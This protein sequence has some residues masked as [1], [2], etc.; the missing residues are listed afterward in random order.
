MSPPLLPPPDSD[1]SVPTV[2]TLPPP[3]KLKRKYDEVVAAAFDKLFTTAPDP[4]DVVKQL[5]LDIPEKPDPWNKLVK[6]MRT[7]ATSAGAADTGGL[8]HCVN[9]L[10]PDPS[11]TPLV[12]PILKNESKSDQHV[13]L[14]SLQLTPAAL[15]TSTPDTLPSARNILSPDTLTPTSPNTSSSNFLPRRQILQLPR[16]LAGPRIL[17]ASLFTRILFPLIVFSI[18][19]PPMPTM[20]SLQARRTPLEQSEFPVTRIYPN[21]IL[22]S[23]DFSTASGQAPPSVDP[24]QRTTPPHDASEYTA[25]TLKWNERMVFGDATD[26][27]RPAEEAAPNASAEILTSRAARRATEH[28]DI[29]LR[30]SLT[31]ILK[32]IALFF[33]QTHRICIAFNAP[34]TWLP[35]ALASTHTHFC[36]RSFSVVLRIN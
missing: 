35:F 10:L 17:R 5:Y 8:D 15:D 6:V 23:P 2:A 18:S 3:F 33:A 16:H 34:R 9:Y 12:P 19:G 36:T 26:P 30:L 25:E 24:P 13:I 7:A 4:V 32:L 20:N 14:P 11:K 28:M 31:T 1:T 21:P 29:R 27:S 22:C